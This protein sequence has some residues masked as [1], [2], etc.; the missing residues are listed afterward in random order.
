M[1]N[2]RS[3]RR[4]RRALAASG[5]AALVGSFLPVTAAFAAAAPTLAY[6]A[7]GALHNGTYYAKSNA[8]LTLT[9]TTD[10]TVR[11]VSVSGITGS[12]RSDQAKTTW[13]FDVP[14]ASGSDVAQ[15]KTVTVGEGANNNGVCNRT[16]TADI[17]YTLDNTLPGLTGAP[18][19]QPN[20]TNGWYRGDV[21]V[22]WSASDSGSGI[23]DAPANSTIGGEGVNLT[24]SKTVSDRVGNDR[25]A[26]SS[27]AV[28]I[29]RNAPVSEAE[30]PASTDWNNVDQTVVLKAGDN[31]SGVASIHYQLNDGQ[32]VANTPTAEGIRVPI[33]AEGTHT[34]KYWSVDN[35]GNTETA[36]TATIKIDKTK[37]TINHTQSP[38]ANDNGWNNSNVTVKFECADPGGSGI[39]SCTGV[40]ADGVNNGV[41]TTTEGRQQPVTGTAVDNAGNS[42]EDPAT[43]SIDK[44][45]PTIDVNVARPADRNGWYNRDVTVGFIY[46]DKL[47]G[48]ASNGVSS[49]TFSDNGAN[50]GVRVEATDAADN[51]HSDGVSGINVD[52]DAPQTSSD[53]PE[54]WQRQDVTVNFTAEDQEG[55]SGVDYTEY[56]VNGGDWVKARSV[57]ITENG[58]HALSFR[59]VDRAGNEEQAHNRSLSIDKD[60][61]VITDGGATAAAGGNAD[62]YTSPVENRF[63]AEDLV[64]GLADPA[65]ADFTKSSGTTEEGSAVKVNSGSVADVAGNTSPGIDS[66]PF[67]IDL[68]AP[69]VTAGDAPAGANDAGWYNSAVKA[70]FTAED[71]VSGLADPAQAS[72][73]KSSG[74]LEGDA[75]K[76]N[77]GS[78]ADIAGHS[79]AGVDSPALKID[80]AAPSAPSFS[81]IEA[82]TYTVAPAESSISCTATDAVSGFAGCTFSGYSSATGTHTL[83]ATARDNAG[84]TSTST[85][86]YTIASP[87]LLKGFY[88]PIGEAN[89]IIKAPGETGPTAGST[90]V[91]NTAKGGSTIPLKFE[92]YKDGVE[93]T[94][95][96]DVASFAATKLSSCTGTVTDT[97]EE[98]STA[99]LTSLRYDTADGGQFIQNWKTS[100][101]SGDTCYRVAL[102]TTDKSVIYTFVRL[103]K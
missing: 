54:G 57:T 50:Q 71:L 34:L 24:T 92:V 53:A 4:S 30:A 93:S 96:A 8:T 36:Q 89:S 62:W 86:T 83:T 103:R 100:T 98:L 18:T 77:S 51:K 101:V 59:S 72:F 76:V 90:T 63:T 91:W 66:K 85:L 69:T 6:T 84:H 31:L 95:T 55:L 75:V 9:V 35:A 11:C 40:D 43:V 102:T 15:E 39:K 26:S 70:A 23:A 44:T 52:K 49:K 3:Y 94:S 25:T 29:D 2:L 99:G 87:Y 32:T 78:V 7:G 16:K 10:N 27:P 22:A 79:N 88:A 73:T 5:A 19:A 20:G 82:K 12:Q 65:Q 13:T 37:P 68:S 67:K 56:K 81:G 38:L 45:K 14:T 61:P 47:S 48:V 80:L 33:T 60:G 42:V 46:D 1:S 21:T 17:F 74:D 58:V 28:K 97:V 41:T 64:S